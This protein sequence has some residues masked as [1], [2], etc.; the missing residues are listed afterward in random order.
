[1][2]YIK[3]PVFFILV[4]IVNPLV[5]F[6]HELQNV[7]YN[8]IYSQDS[9]VGYSKTIF[10]ETEGKLYISTFSTLGMHVLGTDNNINITTNYTLQDDKIYK[11]DFKL[12][13]SDLSIKSEGVRQGNEFKITNTT[14]SGVSTFN[15]PI[16]KEPLAAPYVYR[17]LAKQ[18]LS[19]GKVY[20]FTIFEPS[21]LLL[22]DEL[23]TDKTEV[24][25]LGKERL[26]LPMGEYNTYKLSLL[27]NGS[28]S[29]S[30]VT[31]DGTLVKYV[32]SIG[33]TTYKEVESNKRNSVNSM[34]NIV[35]NTAISSNYKIDNPRELH[36][37]KLEL[38][39]L[40]SLDD[41][42]INDNGRQT[43]D[44]DI[45]YIKMERVDINDS[46]LNKPYKGK[47]DYLQNT[48][49]IQSKSPEIKELAK[50]ITK[51]EKNPYYEIMSINKWVYQNLEKKP[52][53]SIPNALDILRTRKGDCN[54]HAVLF[55][56]LARALNIP[57]KIAIG[58]VYINEKFYYHAWNEV[59]LGK[60]ITVDPTFNQFPVDASHVKFFE[61]DMKRS[62]E[63]MK[64]VGKIK[65]KVLDA[66]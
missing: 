12:K 66:S 52:T 27:S 4:I 14:V 17:W 65:I 19:I 60:W 55:T 44:R 1:M 39:G 64:L 10:K 22:G 23:T 7:E 9:R 8:G 35:E 21:V 45:L 20:S 26:K 11:F 29:T 18:G 40:D 46:I 6:P 25:V 30:W 53:L 50:S 5:L 48:N 13:S 16:K 56:A 34:A 31:D 37:L 36:S 61:G 42:D 3:Y 54:E 28:E 2:I 58:I 49:A 41:F 24:K 62:T 38:A 63:I 51:G 43:L 47:D 15:V 57:T 59:F 32:S 33:L